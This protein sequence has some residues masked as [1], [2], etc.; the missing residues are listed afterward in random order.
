[1]ASLKTVYMG[2]ELKNPVIVGASSLTDRMDT[3]HQL[4]ESGAGALVLASIF[5]EQIQLERFKLEE[6]LEKF[7]NLYAEM[8][9]VFPNLEHA[10]AEEHL[11]WVRKAKESVRIP[12]IASLNAVI[13]E[14]WVEYARQLQDTGVDGLELNFFATPS[15]F[16]TEGA[17]VEAEQ[18]R[19]LQDVKKAI[20]VPIS[21][22]LS[23][24]YTNPLNFIKKLDEVGVN[25]FV[26]FNRFFQP[27]IAVEKE[28]HISP[29]NLSDAK[30]NRIPLRYAG[31]LHGNIKGD[32][33]CSTGI[34]QGKDV[35]KMILAGATCVQCVT[36]LFENE[37]GHLRTMVQDMEKWMEGKGYESLDAFR[38]KM[39]RKN[40]TDPWIYT[41]AQYVKMLLKPKSKG[42][43]NLE[44]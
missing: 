42:G 9:D 30:D 18:L 28:A 33:C 25:A 39:S 3:I 12:V 8:A 32:I 7:D 36:T 17:Q 2:I 26:L 23:I 13:R 6:E 27:D 22:K 19:T 43:M 41:R 31:L 1:M 16:N 5:E 21:V 44:E 14:T 34:M 15:D 20:T 4:E 35:V 37:V 29:W 11:T 38:G 10:G 40:S 24:Q